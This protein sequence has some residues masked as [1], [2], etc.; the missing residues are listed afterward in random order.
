MPTMTYANLGKPVIAWTPR[1]LFAYGADGYWPD[2]ENPADG[3]LFQDVA[4]T[5][6]ATTFGQ[7]VGLAQRLAG[8][9][10]LKQ[11]TAA[12]RPTTAREPKG[13]R[14]NLWTYSQDFAQNVWVKDGSGNT[15]EANAAL[16]PDG[17]MTATRFANAARMYRYVEFGV[18]N[19]TPVAL[20]FYAKADVASS[21]TIRRGAIPGSGDYTIDLI[22]GVCTDPNV[23]LVSAGSGWWRV[24]VKCAT[25]IANGWL[26]IISAGTIFIWGAQYDKRAD[27][28]PYQKVTTIYDVTEAG[29]PDVW[30]LRTDGTDDLLLS[31]ATFDVNK[32][33]YLAVCAM[34]PAASTSGA[35]TGTL[36]G[37]HGQIGGVPKYMRIVV[38]TQT[39]RTLY[40]QQATSG[41][42][43]VNTPNSVARYEFGT[44]FIVEGWSDGLNIYSQVNGGAL[45]VAARPLPDLPAPV[46]L[47]MANA[48]AFGGTHYFDAI[49][50]QRIPDATERAALRAEWTRRYLP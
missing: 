28:T 20:S 21:F 50:L 45:N 18:A 14:R 31:T 13:G 35:G 44:P 39:N 49:A 37:L 10:N 16:A 30:S 38:G 7:P 26:A 29:V 40:T 36:F 24:V 5:L 33:T 43:F 25:T 11:A 4:A 1:D 3:R 27:A 47:Q 32:P 48:A 9:A 2:G 12:A 46:P 22:A 8:S 23:V 6:P 41:G 17:T 19:V 34:V 42:D 15:L